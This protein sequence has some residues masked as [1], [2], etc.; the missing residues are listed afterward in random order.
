MRQVGKMW[1]QTRQPGIAGLILALLSVAYAADLA[2]PAAIDSPKMRDPFTY[3]TAMTARDPLLWPFSKKSI[4]NMPIGSK[5]KYVP[6]ELETPI[7]GTL[8]VDEDL[9]ILTPTEPLMDVY[10]NDVGWKINR[11]RL[12][13]TGGLIGRYPIPR[14]FEVSPDNWDG[15]TP[16]LGAAILMPDRR[17]IVQTQPFAHR[18]NS[19][20]AT[21]RDLFPETDIYGDGYYGAHGG[22]GL[23][24]I[25]GTLRLDELSPTSGPIRHALKINLA[26]RRNCYYDDEVKGFRWPAITEDKDGPSRYGRERTKSVP[27]P[28]GCRVG[29]L[30]AIPATTNLDDFK[31]ET[32][33]GKMLA[34][35]FQD[36]GAYYVDGTGWNVFAIE[37]EWSPAGRFTSNF[38]K[39]W[40]F[41]FISMK[42]D[43]PWARDIAKIYAALC[44]VDNNSPSSVGGGGTPRAPLAPPFLK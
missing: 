2:S 4:W 12:E 5:A 13:I 8:T 40:S 43:N 38:K 30:F 3:D 32:V 19:P 18:K 9:I 23:S 34:K 36:Y 21:S 28:K 35:A 22:S 44:I 42:T 37:T 16:N 26:G 39:N 7:E 27:I 1:Q 31:F 14:S 33:P 10:Y 17:T 20:Y 24:A 25:G 41:E 6:A 11:D 29:A 15:L